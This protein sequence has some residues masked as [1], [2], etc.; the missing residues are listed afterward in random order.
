MTHAERARAIHAADPSLG[1][2]AIAALIT[3]RTRTPC[4]RQQVAAALASDPARKGGR[5]LSPHVTLRVP[6]PRRLLPYLDARVD[7][8]AVYSGRADALLAAAEAELVPE[9]EREQY[10][11]ARSTL[12]R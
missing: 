10:W 5:P 4:T 7:G 6:V 1:P 8:D 2:S 11:G 9:G 12:R 3:R